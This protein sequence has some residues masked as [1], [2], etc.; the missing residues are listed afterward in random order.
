MGSGLSP[1]LASSLVC[2]DPSSSFIKSSALAGRGKPEELAGTDDG[3]DGWRRVA[4]QQRKYSYY[5]LAQ[6]KSNLIRRNV[7]SNLVK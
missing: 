4:K 2:S 1:D 3:G 6:D 7:D 5:K